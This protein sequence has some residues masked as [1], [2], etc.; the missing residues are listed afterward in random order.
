[1]EVENIYHLKN[2]RKDVLSCWLYKNDLVKYF[3]QHV[4]NGVIMKFDKQFKESISSKLTL[5]L[6]L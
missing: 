5:H 4:R 2:N 3:M 6:N 1:M